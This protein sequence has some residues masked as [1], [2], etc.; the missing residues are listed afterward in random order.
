VCLRRHL[1]DSVNSHQ[2]FGWSK[3]CSFAGFGFDCSSGLAVQSVALDNYFHPNFQSGTTNLERCSG[4]YS[5]WTDLEIFFCGQ[6]IPFFCFQ[7]QLP[8]SAVSGNWGMYDS[9]VDNSEVQSVL[10]RNTLGASHLYPLLSVR[11]VKAE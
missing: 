8:C 2:T 1:D 4:G 5:C 3:C 9:E 6:I 11:S 10:P 7:G